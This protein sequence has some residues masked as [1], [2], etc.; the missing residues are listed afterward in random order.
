[1]IGRNDVTDVKWRHQTSNDVKIA[2]FPN[3][4]VQDVR[5]RLRERRDTVPRGRTV[6]LI[7]AFFGL[8][9]SLSLSHCFFLSFFLRLRGFSCSFLFLS[10]FSFCWCSSTGISALLRL[11][12]RI[13][14]PPFPSSE[15][16]IPVE[17]YTCMSSVDCRAISAHQM[18]TYSLTKWMCDTDAVM[19]ALI[20]PGFG[21]SRGELCLVVICLPGTL[22]NATGH[23]QK[24]QPGRCIQSFGPHPNT[25]MLYQNIRFADCPQPLPKKIFF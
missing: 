22:A 19:S 20:T 13:S 7:L 4:R 25:P 18:Y 1:M 8:F 6:C 11:A 24:R 5:S 15:Y 3:S 21:P 23:S 10:H 16:V 9:P 2:H 14:Q 12:F 17:K